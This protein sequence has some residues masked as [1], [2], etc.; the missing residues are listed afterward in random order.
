MDN[1]VEI[2]NTDLNMDRQ[3]FIINSVSYVSGSATMSIE[4]V[5][6]DQLPIV[7]QVTN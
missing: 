6:V 7:G 4:I 3:R 5:N 1:L 2:K